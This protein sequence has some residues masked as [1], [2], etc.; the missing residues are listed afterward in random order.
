ML[1]EY[2][3]GARYNMAGL[4]GDGLLGE[5]LYGQDLGGIPFFA[6]DSSDRRNFTLMPMAS[7]TQ[8]GTEYLSATA[9]ADFD[10]SASGKFSVVFCKSNHW[11][12]GN[13]LNG[14]QAGYVGLWNPNTASCWL[15]GTDG[16][17]HHGNVITLYAATNSSGSTN[18]SLQSTSDHDASYV[19]GY[20]WDVGAA[21]YDATQGTA[22]NRAIVYKDGTAYSNANSNVTI[23]G[24]LP[25]T[26]QSGA[27]IPLN[28]GGGYGNLGWRFFGAMRCVMYFVGRVLSPT[29]ITTLTGYLKANYTF[30]DIVNAGFSL[31]N[32][33][34]AFDLSEPSGQS[35]FDFSTKGHH[36]AETSGA[37][38]NANV[39]T[40]VRER[41]RH[42][43]QM[44]P[45]RVVAGSTDY[46]ANV[47]TPQMLQMAPEWV[48]SSPLNGQ[49]AIRIR[50]G[51]GLYCKGF[52]PISAVATDSFQAFYLNQLASAE[53][54]C[55]TS[56]G[57][58]HNYLSYWGLGFTN[59]QVAAGGTGA[60]LRFRNPQTAINGSVYGNLSWAA[61]TPLISS[62]RTIGS[63]S[64]AS[65][66]H[67][68]NG[69]QDT[70][71][72]TVNTIQNTGPSSVYPRQN[73]GIGVL[74]RSGDQGPLNAT[75]G[76]YYLGMSL[77]CAALPTP[78]Q[79]AIR[80]RLRA[81]YGT[82]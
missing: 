75:V 48:A 24:T 74:A 41:G 7:F 37:V 2:G 27:S 38:A 33:V 18:A 36:L 5:V 1:G 61:T 66:E 51:R 32:L 26:L 65:H 59:A 9:S 72:Y 76:D 6:F 77:I 62:W 56:A 82:G 35:R 69:A 47:Y 71:T 50:G 20:P 60:W 46:V 10:P 55:F 19:C 28:I 12:Q 11:D 43:F 67:W 68:L 53:T 81:L 57:E 54:F 14:I 8:A 39:V 78:Q 73:V 63:G 31:S 22:A 4:L 29:E 40:S 3:L 70:L 45:P 79:Q 44:Y 80:D 30:Q 17:N 21:T 49:P 64:A 34:A 42:S 13:S 15:V 16:S 52:S 58:V 25:G 23:S